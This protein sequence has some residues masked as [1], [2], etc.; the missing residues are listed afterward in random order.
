LGNLPSV[1][2]WT[3]PYHVSCFCLSLY[4]FK[5]L[6]EMVWCLI[7]NY[8]SRPFFVCWCRIKNVANRLW[9]STSMWYVELFCYHKECFH[10]VHWLKLV[11]YDVMLCI[12]SDHNQGIYIYTAFTFKL[13]RFV[14]V[15]TLFITV[16]KFHNPPYLLVVMFLLFGYVIQVCLV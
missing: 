2:L 11:L 10:Y 16:L 8:V 4:L 6:R 12:L 5:F 13:I 15:P 1:I 9:H 3:W 14:L 7:F